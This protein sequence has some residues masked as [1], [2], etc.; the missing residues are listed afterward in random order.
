MDPQEASRPKPAMDSRNDLLNQIRVG[1]E[2]R[3]V[4]TNKHAPQ[5]AP[6]DESLEGMAGALARA[7]ENRFNVIHSDSDESGNEED[8]DDDWDE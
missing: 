4:E 2:L 7:L 5:P 6:V 8:E 1:K 3:P